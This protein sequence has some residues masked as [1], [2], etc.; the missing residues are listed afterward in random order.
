MKE[1]RDDFRPSVIQ[2]I[3]KRI[4]V[5][6][7][8]VVIFEPSYEC[9]EFFGANVIHDLDEFKENAHIIVAKRHSWEL[10]DVADKAFSRDI[11]REN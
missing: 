3:V 2:G 10:S 11:S 7:I 5:K 1:G 9:S 8:E 6:G 4:K